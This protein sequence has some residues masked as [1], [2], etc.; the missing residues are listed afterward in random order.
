MSRIRQFGSPAVRRG[1]L[2]LV[3]AVLGL[4]PGAPAQTP[5][6]HSTPSGRPPVEEVR[7]HARPM[8]IPTRAPVEH[9]RGP[10]PAIVIGFAGAG[11]LVAMVGL[12]K[13]ITR[14]R[15]RS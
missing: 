1:S 10:H 6:P 8:P 3:A 13:L 2:I 15:G 12:S 7:R 11:A 4:A 9:D 5:P 14:R